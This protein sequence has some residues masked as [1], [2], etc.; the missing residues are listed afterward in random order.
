MPSPSLTSTWESWELSYEMEDKVRAS[1]HQPQP[2]LF[3]T[4]LGILNR[5]ITRE[6]LTKG[7]ET[8]AE[9]LSPYPGDMILCRKLQRCHLQNSCSQ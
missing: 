8:R 6:H 7:I 4:V 3:S 5:T 1:A 9:E 2:L